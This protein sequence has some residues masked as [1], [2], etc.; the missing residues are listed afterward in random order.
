MQ[1]VDLLLWRS[2]ADGKITMIKGSRARQNARCVGLLGPIRSE[3]M[4]VV[5]E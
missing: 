1:K 4:V 2:R 5:L 3:K